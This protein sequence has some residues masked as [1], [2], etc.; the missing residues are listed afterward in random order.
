MTSPWLY[1]SLEFTVTV[2]LFTSFLIGGPSTLQCN[3][4]Q[5]ACLDDS[6]C[7]HTTWMCDG[8]FDCNDESDE[9]ADDCGKLTTQWKFMYTLPYISRERSDKKPSYKWSTVDRHLI[10]YSSNYCTLDDNSMYVYMYVVHVHVQC[11]WHACLCGQPDF[12]TSWNSYACKDT[13]VPQTYPPEKYSTYSVNDESLLTICC[14]MNF[15]VVT[16]AR[17]E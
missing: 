13:Q 4:N 15:V 11:S 3:E 10:P 2:S 14:V 9:T 5:F 6:L 17:M 8:E 12:E 1:I 7:I 16:T